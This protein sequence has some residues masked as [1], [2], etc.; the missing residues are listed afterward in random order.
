MVGDVAANAVMSAASET[1][2]RFEF[3][4][5]DQQKLNCRNFTILI[6]STPPP[7]SPSV[8][9]TDSFHGNLQL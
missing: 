3:P 6:K 5:H 1:Q 4:R 9:K 2:P 8:P 7:L